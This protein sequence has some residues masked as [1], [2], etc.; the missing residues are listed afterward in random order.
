M[1]MG[2]DYLED[3]EIRH[4]MFESHIV[5]MA[6]NGVWNTRDGRVIN[7]KDMETS[8]LKSTVKMLERKGDDM[9]DLHIAKMKREIQ[10]REMLAWRKMTETE[11]LEANSAKFGDDQQK[12]YFAQLRA[13]LSGELNMLLND[14]HDAAWQ[15]EKASL[16]A[17]LSGDLHQQQPF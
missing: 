2:S 12:M 14:N 7:I 9:W 17:F 16:A 10:K 11:W 6:C 3:M 4:M 5:D 15:E 13:I 1:S 8:H